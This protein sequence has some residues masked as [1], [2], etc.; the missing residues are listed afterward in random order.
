MLKEAIHK[1]ALDL[2]NKQ[3]DMEKEISLCLKAGICPKC[4]N[5]LEVVKHKTVIPARSS[6]VFIFWTSYTPK[7]EEETSKIACSNGCDLGKYANP[8][9]EEYEKCINQKIRDEHNL[10]DWD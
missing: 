1:K 4:G 7:Q 2:V 6:K 5:N 10:L 9:C 8:I 3:A